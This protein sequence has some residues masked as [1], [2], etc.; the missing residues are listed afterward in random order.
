MY[1]MVGSE[2]LIRLSSVTLP[3]CMGTLKST[4]MSTR[5]PLR[6]ISFTVFLFI[7]DLRVGATLPRCGQAARKQE[8]NE[9]LHTS[10]PVYVSRE[11]PYRLFAIMAARSAVRTE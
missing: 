10:V 1:W 4:R 9:G 5:L 8:Y 7:V 11:C 6:S 2:A 3:S